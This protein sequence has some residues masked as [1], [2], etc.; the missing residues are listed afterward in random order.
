MIRTKPLFSA[1]LLW[2]L[3]FP[4]PASALSVE[5][6]GTQLATEIVGASC[7]DIA[8]SYPGL[9][10][11]ASEKSQSPRICYNSNKVNSIAVLNATFIAADPIKTA[12]VI[13]F[14]H[15]FPPGINGKIM[16]RAKLQG[17]FS[18]PHG[19]GVPVGDKL[20]F[21]ASFSQSNHDDAIAEP[22]DLT[23]GDDMDSAL[24]DYSVK[25][26]YLISGTRVLKGALKIV[27]NSVGHRLTLADKSAITIDTGSTM[28]DKLEDMAPQEPVEEAAPEKAETPDL[29][30]SAGKPKPKAPIAFPPPGG[31]P[32]LPAH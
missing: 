25:E 21:S 8:G 3:L 22:L 24:F 12:V 5:I 15:E 4:A 23:V 26:K 2:P 19:V 20:A 17:F 29:S 31:A 9:I 16:S 32:A 1:C 11:E 28:A 6:Q 30:P 14:E 7:I 13:R 10:I 18:T 27:F